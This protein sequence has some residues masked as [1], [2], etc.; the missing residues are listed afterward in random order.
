MTDSAEKIIARKLDLILARDG[1][2]DDYDQEELDEWSA[3]IATALR[4]EGHL[5]GETGALVGEREER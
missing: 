2:G 1:F 5:P 4:D 3:E